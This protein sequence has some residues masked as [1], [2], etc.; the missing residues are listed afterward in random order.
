MANTRKILTVLLGLMLLLTLSPASP[1]AAEIKTLGKRCEGTR[2]ERC[3]WINHDTT[4]N[5]VRGYGSVEDKTS[6]SIAVR[7]SVTLLKWNYSYDR[8]EAVSTSVPQTG[9]EFARAGTNVVNCGDGNLFRADAVWEWN[10]TDGGTVRSSSV[11]I[12]LC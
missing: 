10:G 6:G 4:N 5:R 7:V 9:Y 8:W 11:P 1:A 12:N 2:A 3:A